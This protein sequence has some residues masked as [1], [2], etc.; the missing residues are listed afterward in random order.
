MGKTTSIESARTGTTT[1]RAKGRPSG[2]APS[3]D[4]LELAGDE[5]TTAA[6]KA[7][8]GKKGEQQV[9]QIVKGSPALQAIGDK[10]LRLE[11]V[12][13]RLRAIKNKVLANYRDL[14]LREGLDII[15]AQG[16]RI[17]IDK[18][19]KVKLPAFA[20]YAPDED[21]TA[22]VLK[23]CGIDPADIIDDGETDPKL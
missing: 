20:D 6:P 23:A 10:V 17:V 19:P 9:M 7:K 14:A 5:P 21:P 22:A 3:P 2:A 11:F 1:R 8:G 13:R 18:A 12:L 4:P 15:D 16:Q